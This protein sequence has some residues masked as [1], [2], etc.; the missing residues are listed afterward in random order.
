MIT[1]QT[2]VDQLEL[3]RA[4][5]LQVRIGL[6]LIEDGKEIDCKWHRTVITP[7]ADVDAQMALVNANLDQMDRAPVDAT[8][9]ARIKQVAALLP[10]KLA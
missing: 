4:G 5:T 9:V 7:G 2:V 3:T 10:E 6:L 1:K 8:G